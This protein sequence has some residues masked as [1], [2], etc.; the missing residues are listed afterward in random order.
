M[1]EQA[2]KLSKSVSYSS[3]GT[4]EFIVDKDKNF[5]ISEI[6]IY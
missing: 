3:A 4:V 2:I 5:L 1:G 6:K